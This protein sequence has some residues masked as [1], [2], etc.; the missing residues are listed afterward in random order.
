MLSITASARSGLR[1]AAAIRSATNLHSSMYRL[2]ETAGAY[3]L[4]HCE[5]SA[6]VDAAPASTAVVIPVRRRMTARCKTTTS[7]FCETASSRREADGVS[8]NSKGFSRRSEPLTESISVKPRTRPRAMIPAPH[9]SLHSSRFP[10]PSV[11]ATGSFVSTGVALHDNAGRSVRQKCPPT[12]STFAAFKSPCGTPIA[13]S[14]R[15]PRRSDCRTSTVT[16]SVAP[17]DQILLQSPPTSPCACGNT[18]VITGAG[19]SSTAD[20]GSP[21]STS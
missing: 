19:E 15:S 20:G 21:S 10:L 11:C 3:R 9:M 1:I 5:V 16:S 12:Y 17:F 8:L 13:C 18:L 6:F 14:L 2:D 7:Q 4:S